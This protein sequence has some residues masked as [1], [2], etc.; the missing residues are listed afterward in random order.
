MILN[1]TTNPYSF[2]LLSNRMGHYAGASLETVSTTMHSHQDFYETILVLSG[3]F[4]HVCDNISTPIP[5]GTLILLKPGSTHHLHTATTNSV[6]FVLCI[7]E[8]HF[9]EFV[10]RIFPNYPLDAMD[11]YVSTQISNSKIK[12]VESLAR[13]LASK[14]TDKALWM[15]E[16]II[17]LYLS[18]FVNQT[19]IFECNHYAMDIVAKID[20]QLYMN[21]S[22]KDICA[23]YPYSQCLLLRQ[24]KAA[25]GYT[26]VEYKTKQKMKY[27]CELL[28][29]TDLRMLDIAAL[30]RY[31][32]QS[33]FVHAFKKEMGVTPSEY[34]IKVL[35]KSL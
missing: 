28:T 35:E 22:V 10:N 11:S 18:S 9:R 14:N 12:Y 19:N 29:K 5:A 31:E 32:S 8:Q 17:Y 16:E 25:T 33:Y 23:N 24:F 7:E 4:D 34:R 15:A 3:Q 26:I 6:H 2:Q 13:T 27:A 21:S 20:N 1:K 30:L